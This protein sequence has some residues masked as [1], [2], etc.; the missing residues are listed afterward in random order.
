MRRGELRR[1]CKDVLALK[2]RKPSLPTLRAA[3][4]LFLSFAGFGASGLLNYYATDASV[5][6]ARWLEI[7]FWA[8]VCVGVAVAIVL[9][10]WRGAEQKA[11]DMEI[12]R[13][14]DDVKTLDY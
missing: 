13:I 3:S 6:P 11:F 12:E 4:L 8:A 9:W 5:R 1:I 7:C 2:V 14:A 10:V